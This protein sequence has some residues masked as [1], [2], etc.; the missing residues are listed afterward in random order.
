M[1]TEWNKTILRTNVKQPIKQISRIQCQEW[2]SYRGTRENT[3]FLFFFFFTII[4]LYTFRQRRWKI[5][6]SSLM[7]R[8]SSRSRYFLIYFATKFVIQDIIF[9]EQEYF[10]RVLLFIIS[11]Y[12]ILR[13]NDLLFKLNVTKIL[14]LRDIYIRACFCHNPYT[15]EARNY[16]CDK[17]Y[18]L[19]SVCTYVRGLA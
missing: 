8:L 12:W 2:N 14:R 5:M 11:S 19:A 15:N 9:V 3:S 4:D 1:I 13:W 7:I 17:I 10:Q 16:W 6:K 18:K